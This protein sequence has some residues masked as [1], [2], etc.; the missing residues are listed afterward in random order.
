MER[1]AMNIGPLEGTE[2][3][4]ETEKVSRAF[5]IEESIRRVRRFRENLMTPF[6]KAIRLYDLL[7]PGAVSCGGTWPRRSW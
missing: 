4:A 7:Q 5:E 1:E 2:A 6:T 3:A